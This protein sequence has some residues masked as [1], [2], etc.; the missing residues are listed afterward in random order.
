MS[1]LLAP[2]PVIGP[3]YGEVVSGHNLLVYMTIVLVP[4][5]GI[6]IYRTRFGLRLRAVG[7]NPHAVDTAGIGVAAMRYRAMMLWVLSISLASLV[8]ALGLGIWIAGSVTRPVRDL[9]VAAGR[10]RSGDYDSPV[11]VARM[12]ELGR[13]AA[14]L[15]LTRID[16]GEEAANTVVLTP[17]LVIRSSTAGA[18]C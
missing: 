15:I 12:D 8:L 18:D 2:I 13:L 6:L 1:D 14:E 7:E 16:G 5:V 9:S 11:P 10:I 4:L 3:L 17:E